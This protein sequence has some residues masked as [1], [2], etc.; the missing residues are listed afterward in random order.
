M[1]YFLIMLTVLLLAIAL[2]ATGTQ[3]GVRITDF[4]NEPV[5]ELSIGETITTINHAPVRTVQEFVQ[6]VKSETG[7]NIKVNGKQVPLREGKIGV[8]VEQE[9]KYPLS[10]FRHLVMAL[11]WLAA[12][13]GIASLRHNTMTLNIFNIADIGLTSIALSMGAQELNPLATAAIAN[14]GFWAVAAFKITAVLTISLLL[15]KYQLS[16]STKTCSAAYMAV[17]VLNLSQLMRIIFL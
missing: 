8:Y 10:F 11:P 2:Q 15:R 3:Q 7:G 14:Y 16:F 1:K 9:V 5:K 12:I 17:I 6:A 13:A 4:M